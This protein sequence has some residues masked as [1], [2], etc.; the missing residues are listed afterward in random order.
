MNIEELIKFSVDLN[1]AT[2]DIFKDR[3]EIF[4]ESKIVNNKKRDEYLEQLKHISIEQWLYYSSYPW[5][6]E[7]E[8]YENNKEAKERGFKDWKEEMLRFLLKVKGFLE[9]WLNKKQKEDKKSIITAWHHIHAWWDIIIWNNNKNVINEIDK[10]LDLISRSN[11]EE[12]SKITELL[13]EFKKTND[14][15]K[16][17]DVFSILW[18]WASINSM[19]I[20]L[21]SLIN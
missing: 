15:T 8:A 21:G 17:V 1:P 18:S 20:A 10:I 14:K 2:F 9:S 4:V 7:E 19:I 13:E 16:L 5:I 11:L 6:N 3:V 12:K